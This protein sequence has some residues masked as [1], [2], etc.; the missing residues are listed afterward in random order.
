VRTESDGDPEIAWLE[1]CEVELSG[2]EHT[3]E[4]AA[5]EEM[6]A[7]RAVELSAPGK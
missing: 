4:I 3:L 7:V 1:V 2:G 6:V 5:T